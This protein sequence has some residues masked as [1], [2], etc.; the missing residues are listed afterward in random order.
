[1]RTIL[2]AT[3][4]LLGALL[5]VFFFGPS[6]DP[7]STDP[8]MRRL[9]EL[10]ELAERTC[11]SNTKSEQSATLKV[12]LDLLN[13]K[14]KGDSGVSRNREAVR[15]AAESLSEELKKTESEEIRKCMMPWA[16]KLRELANSLG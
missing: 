5:V 4:V 11:L 12:N 1:M 3:A 6:P 2:A 8:K 13:A 10:T 16:E 14:S 7:V 15:G 9:A